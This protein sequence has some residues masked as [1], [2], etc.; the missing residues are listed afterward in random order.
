MSKYHRDVAKAIETVVVNKLNGDSTHPEIK[1]KADMEMAELLSDSIEDDFEHI[2]EAQHVGNSYGSVGDIVIQ[3]DDG[4]VFLELKSVESGTGT[5]SNMG[6]DVLTEFNLFDGADSWTKFR[7]KQNHSQWVNDE[8]DRFDYP[9][10][11][12][13]REGKAGH[14]KDVLDV[15][16][17]THRKALDVLDGNP[18]DDERLAAEIVHN[19]HERDTEERLEYLNQLN[20]CP[21]NHDNI[22]KFT[23]L[24]VAGNHKQSHI[25]EHWSV[26]VDELES[27]LA[28]YKIYYGNKADQ[29]VQTKDPTDYFAELTNY[30]YSI[31]FDDGNTGLEIVADDG[32]SERKV[33][34]GQLYWGNKFQGIATARIN[35]FEKEILEELNEYIE[36]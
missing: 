20:G 23:L 4:E 11:V 16:R 10:N 26:P 22:R 15:T 14:L 28:N 3:T 5:L 30:K 9:A 6:G 7:E 12:S 18:A 29:S 31:V 24:V 32:D 36:V 1:Q 8:L 34:R 17:N 13:G 33:M 19:I 35:M 21:Q 25:D 27:A 2:H